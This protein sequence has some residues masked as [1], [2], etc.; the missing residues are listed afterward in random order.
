MAYWFRFFWF[1]CCAAC[2]IVVNAAAAKMALAQQHPDAPHYFQLER[3]PLEAA[4]QLF[5]QKTGLSLL[6]ESSLVRNRFSQPVRGTMPTI[7]AL[8]RLLTGTQIQ[9]QSVQNRSYLLHLNAR[10]DPLVKGA[11]SP[12]HNTRM[13]QAILA[14]LC[15]HASAVLHH[16]RIALRV[17]LSPQGQIHEVRVRIA[18]RADH[19]QRIQKLLH[20]LHVGHLPYGVVSNASW[21]IDASQAP[22]ARLCP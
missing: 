7:V 6:Y 15:Q 9:V 22:G 14:Q 17:F 2:F 13:Q 8:E 3:M 1:G 19:E 4:L 16:H 21:L 20:G 11:R 18:T 10:P 12:Q 5:V